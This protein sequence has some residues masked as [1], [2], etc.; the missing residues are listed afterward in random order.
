M[1]F[2]GLDL[3]YATDIHLPSYDD[4]RNL[5]SAKKFA[6]DIGNVFL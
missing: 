2:N 6:I 4:F 5:K 1:T 3:E